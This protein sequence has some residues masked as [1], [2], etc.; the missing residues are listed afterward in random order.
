MGSTLSPYKGTPNQP[1]PP[2]P[3]PF[4]PDTATQ[5]YVFA[6][7]ASHMS[8]LPALVQF[9]HRACFS[10]IVDNWCKV[11]DAGYFITWPGLASKLVLKLL[12]ASI[13]AAKG[14]LRLTCQHVQST[15]DH[16]KRTPP[17]QP[18]HQP[19]MTSGI[20]QAENPARENL[21]CMQPVDVSGQIFTHQ[22]GRF[23]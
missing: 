10:S 17:P 11:I 21:V 16:P 18:I 14:H 4:Q 6:N 23:P 5:A 3:T 20:L 15:R 19:M 13:E 1:P 22:P 12:P 2:L 7:S 8:T 9:H